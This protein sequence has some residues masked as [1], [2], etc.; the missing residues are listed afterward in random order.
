MD[1]D[2]TVPYLIIKLQNFRLVQIGSVCGLDKKRFTKTMKI[3][4]D[5]LENIVGKGENAGLPF[6]KMSRQSLSVY[7]CTSFVT[8]YY[9]SLTSRGTTGDPVSLFYCKPTCYLAFHSEFQRSR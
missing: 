5:N 1:I 7:R 4:F 8:K 6:S 9:R 3:V 2:C